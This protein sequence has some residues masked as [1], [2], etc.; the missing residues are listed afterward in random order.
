VSHCPAKGALDVSLV[1]RKTVD[2]ALF[3]CLVIIILFGSIGIAKLT[4][5]W[6]SAVTYGEYQRIIPQTAHLAHP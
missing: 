6:H 4:G 3:A 2:P 1:K 5:R